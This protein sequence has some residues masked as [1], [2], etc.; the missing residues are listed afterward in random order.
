MNSVK[1]K[2]VFILGAGA[3]ASAH[4]P[5]QDKLLSKVFSLKRTIDKALVKS[6]F[7]SLNI[8]SKLQRVQEYYPKFD[9]YRQNL[10][11]FVIANFSTFEKLNQYKSIIENALKVEETDANAMRIREDLLFEAYNIARS[12]KVS[13]EDL[14]TIFDSVH[15][16]REHFRMYSLKQMA[17]IHNELKLCIIYTLS[18][19]IAESCDNGDYKKFSRYLI[20]R[21]LHASQKEDT[22][23]V[24]TMN[25]DDILENTLFEMCNNYNQSLNKGQKQIHPDLCF[26]DYDLNEKESHIPSVHIK[27]KGHKN[28]KILKMHGSLAWLECP[29]CARIYSDFS[30]EIAAE[31]FSD[32]ECP[33]CKDL[34]RL[35]TENPILRNLII[36]PTFLKSLD[37]LNVKN[38]WHNAFIDVSEADKLVF[39]GYSFPDADFEM[40]CLLKKACKA[41]VK[42]EVVLSKDVDPEGYIGKFT[43]KGFDEDETK[44]LISRMQLPEERYKSF[45]GEDKV[46]FYY[47]GFG[48]YIDQIGGFYEAKGNE[49]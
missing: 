47:N 36:T 34:D 30:N 25:W 35:Q 8:N 21:R 17:D 14:F 43:E 18:F 46:S 31:E 42:I 9:K 1:G 23:A 7:L 2:T 3:S 5:T 24:I 39:I 22:L 38:I 32:L 12:V 10:G 26:Y 27:A 15:S 20:E 48:A 45:F 16:G 4:L 19:S 13:L 40:R 6:D 37:N 29:K 41:S 33:Y 44:D 28:I 49:Q 11:E